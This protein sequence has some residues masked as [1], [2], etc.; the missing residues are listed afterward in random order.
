M[1]K[2]YCLQ[3]ENKILPKTSCLIT[4]MVNRLIMLGCTE[5]KPDDI[6]EI[7]TSDYFKYAFKRKKAEQFADT[8]FAAFEQIGLLCWDFIEGNFIEGD[9]VSFKTFGKKAHCVLVLE[10]TETEVKYFCPVNGE[11]ILSIKDF[12]KKLRGGLVR[13]NL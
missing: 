12:S 13:A 10:K 6:L 2:N 11:K 8:A 3:T 5:I 7:I 4:S 9:V 1:E